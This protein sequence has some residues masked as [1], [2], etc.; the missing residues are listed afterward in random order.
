MGEKAVR[1]ERLVTLI[2]RQLDFF[3]QESSNLFRIF[4]L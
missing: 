1:T 4:N 3:Q 2:Q